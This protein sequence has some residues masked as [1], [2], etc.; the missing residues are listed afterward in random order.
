VKLLLREIQARESTNYRLSVLS[1]NRPR[2]PTYRL[3]GRGD[4]ILGSGR[5]CV[6][7]IYSGQ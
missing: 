2:G 6:I 3:G 7:T 1:L 5:L 4:Q